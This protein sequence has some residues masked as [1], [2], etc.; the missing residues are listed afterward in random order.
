MLGISAIGLGIMAGLAG[1]PSIWFG[2][3]MLAVGAN[4]AFP[5]H[6][7][8]FR[9]QRGTLGL[10]R[11]LILLPYLGLLHGTWH[12]LRMT[13][14]EPPFVEL[15]P[16]ILIGRRL[17][18]HEYPPITTL[19]DL[20]AEIDEHVPN[21]STLLPFPILDGAPAEPAKLREMARQIGESAKPI[22]IHCAQGHGRTSMVAAAVLLELEL[23]RTTDSALET[24]RMVRPGAKPNAAQL[25]ALE[26]A[27]PR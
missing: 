18:A 9:K 3:T 19:V 5:K 6:C 26:A 17:L 1:W 4:Y 23:A 20:T 13:S 10:G 15:A 11:K 12:I 16:G 8:I 2:T 22:Y 27:Y 25:E 21:G 7:P 14:S 24:I